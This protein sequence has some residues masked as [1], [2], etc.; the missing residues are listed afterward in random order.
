[1]LRGKV[2]SP[3]GSVRPVLPAV[4]QRAPWLL[5]AA[6]A[7]M[8]RSGPTLSFLAC[9]GT[10]DANLPHDI[11]YHCDSAE[12]RFRSLAAMIRIFLSCT[13]VWTLKFPVGNLASR[14]AT[15][16]HHGSRPRYQD[17]LVVV[18]RAGVIASAEI[19]MQAC[20]DQL[21]L[22]AGTIQE[23]EQRV[24]QE[25]AGPAPLLDAV[26]GVLLFPEAFPYVLLPVL[27]LP[28]VKLCKFCR[29]MEQA[30]S[31]LHP[32]SGLRPVLQAYTCP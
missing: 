23:A 15:Q 29:Q 26:A 12:S 27:Y 18:L 21:K 13:F 14:S 2:F 20:E 7:V 10:A 28:L 8:S 32:E 25:A 16:N 3:H 5:V 6:K 17:H 24:A 1:M 22:H 30:P 11:G 31:L 9:H 4:L 19:V